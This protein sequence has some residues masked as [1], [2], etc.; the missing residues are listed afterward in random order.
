MA[1]SS[2]KSVQPD[3]IR[4]GRVVLPE[5][6][7]VCMIVK[8]E[9]E[10]LGRC[11]ESIKD[12]AD[13]IIVVDTGSIDNTVS[14][15]KNS[16][17]KVIIDEW[18]NDFSFARNISIANA[19]CEWI[20]WLDADDIVP[21]QSLPVINNLK[22]K[23][24]DCV[25]GFIV[26]NEKPGNTGTE[27]IQARMFPNRPDIFFERKIHEQMMFSALRLGFKLVET[28][29]VVEHHGYAD[30]QTMERKARRNITLLLEEYSI[31][32]AD[33]VMAV[34]I[35][36]SYI[37]TGDI[38]NAKKWYEKVLAIADCESVFPQLAGQACLGLGNIFNRG[39]KYA[40]ATEQF[41]KALKLSPGR[42]DVMFSLAV[43]YDMLGLKNE[44]AGSLL[45][46][47]RG[48]QTPLFI[49]IDFREARIKSFLRLEKIFLECNRISEALEI[50]RQAVAELPLRPEIHNMAG[51]IFF[52]SGKLMDSLHAFEKS[53]Q[54]DIPD[55]IE[56]YT[57]LCMIYACAG[58]KETA[59]DT[60]DSIKPVFKAVPAYWALFKQFLKT[61]PE[62]EIPATINVADI[63]KEEE[64]IRKIFN[65]G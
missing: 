43:S 3:I 41:K 1:K 13:E 25:F 20:L 59:I 45:E 37:I 38:V 31:H 9:A 50:A 42:V 32:D 19:S 35:A 65:I 40:E 6:L 4:R 47:I 17:A 29:A 62:D 64:H 49:G 15:A 36:D 57:G 28:R 22:K 21:P 44:A 61:L 30:S 10:I 56:A 58:K 14:V 16:G 8:N 39:K 48:Q 2:K 63:E 27:F 46:I 24:P 11:I 53:L 26:R 18:K 60:I 5:R 52:R 54:F 51:R 34:E 33:A 7:S 55:N 12:A 23:K